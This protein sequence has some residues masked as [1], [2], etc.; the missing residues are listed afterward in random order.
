MARVIYASKFEVAATNGI[1]PAG[2]AYR[3]WIIGHYRGRRKISDFS[4]EPTISMAY[5]ELPE[6]HSLSCKYYSNSG[7]EISHIKWSFPDDADNDLMW[8]NDIKIGRLDDRCIVEHQILI[9]SIGYSVS[10]ARLS[11]GSPRVIRDIC[12]SSDAHV[13]DM[14]IRATPYVLREDGLVDFIDLLLDERRK[15]PLILLSPHAQGE[16]NA[17]DAAQ[18]ALNLAGVAVVVNAADPDVTWGLSDEIG[19]QLSCFNGAARIYWPGFSRTD[20]PRSHRLFFGAMIEQVG[21]VSARRAIERTVFEVA[22]FRFVADR[23]VSEIMRSVDDA[24]RHERMATT[25]GEEGWR[26]YAVGLEAALSAA[27]DAL[28]DL[29]AENEILKANQNVLFSNFSESSSITDSIYEP[30]ESIRTV[31]DAVKLFSENAKNVELLPSAFSSADESPFMRPTD[32]HDALC[33]LDDIVDEWQRRRDTFGSGGDFL[34]HLR[35]RGWGKRSSMHI[36]DTTRSKFGSHYEFEY[37]NKRQF[38]EPHI[39]IGSGD[40]N[41]CASIHFI[42]DQQ[43]KKIIVAHVGKHLPNTNT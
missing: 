39:T 42:F 36:S 19:R 1:D 5:E 37:Q 18:L 43:R 10:P 20:D 16:S 13:G 11:F 7:S 4:F 6:N 32:I 33:D 21:P 29:Q 24:E 9:E 40:P 12:A 31:I 3:D 15:L 23:R 41:S 34:Q 28:K 38:F 14:Q 26:E 17:I 27:Q 35:D 25:S 8:V 2:G 22:A 30:R